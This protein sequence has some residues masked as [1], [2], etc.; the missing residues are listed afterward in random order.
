MKFISQKISTILLLAAAT[1][2]LSSCQKEDSANSV[3][4]TSYNSID[5]VMRDIEPEVQFFFVSAMEE[6]IIEASNGTQVRIPKNAFETQNGQ[7][8]TGSVT[9]QLQELLKGGSMIASD[10][11][12]TSGGQTL[13]SGG[14]LYFNAEQSGEPLRLADGKELDF[15][16]PTTNPD[17]EMNLFVGN[18][19]GD[20]FD[21][22]PVSNPV[23]LTDSTAG[24]GTDT[25]G[26]GTDTTGTGTDTTGTGG[27]SNATGGW[28][29]YADSLSYYEFTLSTLFNWI[30]CDYFWG[31]PDPLTGFEVC[32]PDGFDDSNSKVYVYVPSLNSVIRT[33]YYPVEKV[34][35]VGSGYFLPI[36]LDVIFVAVSYKDEKIYYS[37]QQ[38]TIVQDH[39]EI[40]T[41]TEVDKQ[42]LA[43]FLQNL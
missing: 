38:A 9:I 8:V 10:K 4:P 19:S 34:F 12:T 16:I 23:S 7:P 41:M 42:K 21:W 20:N 11:P 39:K 2:W 24:A 43:Q 33:F 40:M 26:T 1:L 3:K 27:G 14:Q 32:L 22:Q 29:T 31:S 36:G 30:N 6:S 5:A 17:P 25:T 28:G 13:S 15:K 18:G 37:I 35:T